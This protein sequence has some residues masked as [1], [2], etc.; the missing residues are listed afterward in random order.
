M[1]GNR[2]RKRTC[3]NTCKVCGKEFEFFGWDDRQ[4]ELCS[5][6]CLHKWNAQNGGHH[7]SF[8]YGLDYDPWKTGQLPKTVTQ[9]ALWG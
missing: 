5:K 6:A 4:R 1:S 7:K 8:E 3:R 2:H 9:N